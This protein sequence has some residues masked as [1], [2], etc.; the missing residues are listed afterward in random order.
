MFLKNKNFLWPKKRDELC[1]M[2]NS[3]KNKMLYIQGIKGLAACW[4]MLGHVISHFS[5]TYGEYYPY[6]DSAYRATYFFQ[7]NV[8][9]FAVVS[10]F[11]YS[12]STKYLD[13]FPLLKKIGKRYIRFA[14]PVLLNCLIIL[15]IQNS[16][17][18]FLPQKLRVTD[19]FKFAFIDVF[20]G[21]KY[22]NDVYWMLA[23][24]FWGSIIVM[25]YMN[26]KNYIIVKSKD[27]RYM[28]LVAVV[29]LALAAI[30]GWV[31]AGVMLGCLVGNYIL[32]WEESEKIFLP[33]LLVVEILAYCSRRSTIIA[34][35]WLQFSLIWCSLILLCVAKSTVLKKVCSVPVLSYLGDISFWIY[36]MHMPIVYS[37]TTIISEY[38]ENSEMLGW[39]ICLINIFVTG[40][41]QYFVQRY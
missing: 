20:R 3:M 27:Y 8:G 22:F 35:H 18:L 37:F 31:A 14:V 1:K 32:S 4:V 25:A 34:D 9:M 28:Y 26:I 40:G 24:M 29:C 30:I 10:G 21:E 5:E 7:N 15:G 41:V 36:C 33:M 19:A 39:Q 17:G 11:V 13:L 16:I 23:D 2:E 12:C 38:C 6:I